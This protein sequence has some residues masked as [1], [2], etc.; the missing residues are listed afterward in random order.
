MAKQ[1]ATAFKAEVITDDP[2]TAAKPD[3]WAK[4]P[5]FEEKTAELEA[6]IAGIA[7][8]A[9]GGDLGAVAGSLDPL[10][11]ACKGCHKAFKVKDD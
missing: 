5:E 6:A 1:V 9:A 7:K 10:W 4:W 3:I 2:P 11:D 8:A